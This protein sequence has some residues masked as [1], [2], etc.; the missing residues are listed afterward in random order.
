MVFGSAVGPGIS[1]GLI[2]LGYT[3]PDQMLVYVAYF[4]FA[5]ALV[6]IAV[7]KARPRLPVSRKI[8]VESA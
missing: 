3:F 5:I 8:D 2:D 6:W 7:E 1:G 4:C